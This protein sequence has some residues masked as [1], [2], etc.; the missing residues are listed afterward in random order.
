VAER[1]NLKDGAAYSAFRSASPHGI[2][3]DAPW[4]DASTLYSMEHHITGASPKPPVYAARSNFTRTIQEC[5][6][7]GST[8]FTDISMQR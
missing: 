6:P 5:L 1:L 2:P 8:W 4:P 3:D 7:T